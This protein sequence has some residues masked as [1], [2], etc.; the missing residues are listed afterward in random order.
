MEIIIAIIAIAILFFLVCVVVS[1][2]TY[3]YEEINHT[4]KNFK[5]SLRELW[6]GVEWKWNHR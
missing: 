5:R 2:I 3:I 6:W 4:I 1:A